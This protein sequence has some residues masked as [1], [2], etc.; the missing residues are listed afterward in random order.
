MV[1][2]QANRAWIAACRSPR[3]AVRGICTMRQ[4]G[5]F[6]APESARTVGRPDEARQFGEQAE[7]LRQEPIRA[8]V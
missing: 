8:A 6:A 7:R 3:V 2:S 5:A 4:D 1:A